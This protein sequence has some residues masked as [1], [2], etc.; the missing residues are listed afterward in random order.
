M[1][2]SIGAPG[3]AGPAQEVDS[4][5]ASADRARL[6]AESRLRAFYEISQD[7]MG[8]A[9]G[10]T[11]KQIH[12]NAAHARLFGFDR[13]EDEEGITF[14]ELIAPSERAAVGGVA[15]R[16]STGEL[17][18]LD[19]TTR[20][21]RRDGSEF[22]L[23]V[24]VTT[25]LDGPDRLFAATMRD[26]TERRRAERRLSAIFG[27]AAEPMAFT[28]DGRFEQVNDAFARQFG[29][30][31][32]ED[33]IGRS[34]GELMIPGELARMQARHRQRLAG[35]PPPDRYTTR[36][37]R[38]DGTEFD[39][40]VRTAG[41]V[42]GGRVATVSV[43]RDVTAQLADERRLA[44][45]E[46]RFRDLFE[47][48]PVSLFEI[49]ASR[50]R[51]TLDRLRAEGVGDLRAF[52]GAHPEL[53]AEMMKVFEIVAV[54]A[55]GRAL[56]GASSLEELLAHRDKVYP[57]EVHARYRE[58]ALDLDEGRRSVRFD[59]WVGRLDGGRRWIETAATVV[60][61]HEADWS[62]LLF[63]SVDVTDRR[64]AEEDRAALQERLRLS[65]K[66]EAV[67]RLAGGIAHDFNNILSGILG[68]T[69]LTLLGLDRD[70][71]LHDHQ[72]RIR[73]ATLRARD[74]VRQ[75]LA[76]SRRDSANR[77][78]VDVPTVVKEALTLMRAGIP[79][80]VTL[81]ARIDPNAGT[82]LADPTQL[83]Q[84]VLNLVSNARDAVSAYGRIELAVEPIDLKGEIPG[85]P[86][87]RYVRLRVRDDGAGMD[88]ATRARI[89]EP[90]M[91]TKARAG[92]HGLGL[93]V[94]H[95]IVAAA[96]GAIQ[97]ESSP[98]KGSTFDVYLPRSELSAALESRPASQAQARGER[99]LVVDDE[100]MVRNAHR[101]L[102]ESLGYRVETASDGE[103]ALALFKGAPA[104]F[105]LVLTDQ[106]MPHLSGVD[107][108]K[109]LLAIRADVRVVLCT[110]YSDHVDEER[111]RALGLRAL[112]AKPID[113]ET[114]AAA[115]R[116][117]LG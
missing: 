56:V 40:E 52:T 43:M 106:T 27:A 61:G 99:V 109:A 76:F 115:M 11:G 78:V 79:A 91:T 110:G 19:Y 39:V 18:N 113:R 112:L 51:A 14:L 102:L 17:R 104:S 24:H 100:P 63:A 29:F 35:E 21:L 23:D 28:V 12:V 97:V 84:I 80:S 4:R 44:E 38:Q 73:E 66:L 105:D 94:V 101:R 20:G 77:R 46:R 72:Q 85:L 68:Y 75:I 58:L 96:A 103:Q 98:G 30:A 42:E 111:A 88:E 49:D 92:G 7:A 1:S 32:P 16:L 36:V 2:T 93:A 3:P 86:S 89:F 8:I 37:R 48:V 5:E 34:V 47:F 116:K 64:R 107:L 53:L 25:F 117:A 9:D 57:P 70:S 95:G 26:V 65:E 13:P 90:Y 67:G 114:M 71:E 55:A 87:G 33:A 83:H 74:L 10:A 69:E 54:N 45:S 82:T 59:G 50:V 62:R 60:P 15:A 6:S 81:E 31:R 22:D 108:A 41:L